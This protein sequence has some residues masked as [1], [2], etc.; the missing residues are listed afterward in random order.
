MKSDRPGSESADEDLPKPLSRTVIA[1]AEPK[2]EARKLLDEMQYWE[3]TKIVKRLAEFGDRQAT[4][5]LSIRQFGDFW[6]LRLMGGFVKRLNIRVYFAYVAERNEIVVLM[7]YKKEEDRRTC[8]SIK[9][10]LE[11]RLED[12]LEGK[13]TGISTYREGN[14]SR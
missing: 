10:T 13:R 1:L 4:A 11:D 5:D 12:Y 2:A 9:H 3:A 7:T 8:P 6:E 14:E